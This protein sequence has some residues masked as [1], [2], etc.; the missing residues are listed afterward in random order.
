MRALFRTTACIAVVLP[1]ALYIAGSAFGATI[2]SATNANGTNITEGT[3]D[4]PPYCNGTYLRILGSGFVYDNPNPDPVTGAVT[5]VTI[6]NVPAKQFWVG[7]DITLYAQVGPGATT[8]PVVV[9]TNTGSFSTDS[10]TTTTPPGRVDNGAGTSLAAMTPQYKIL[11]CVSKVTIVKPTVTG[12]KPNPVKGGKFVQIN[13]TGFAGTTSVTVGGK[14]AAFTAPSNYNLVVQ[15]PKSAPN[16]SLTVVVAN[17]A[18]STTATVKLVK[19][20]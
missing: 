13:G 19:K 17:S 7:S 12:I 8:G 14:P 11:P 15:V 18:G 9:Y 5:K 20:G 16:G 10:I 1:F 2:I 6:G 3:A 4:D